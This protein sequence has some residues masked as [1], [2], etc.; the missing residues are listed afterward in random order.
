[1]K[2]IWTLVGPDRGLYAS[3]RLGTL[4]GYRRSRIYGHLD[5]PSALRAIA[6]GGYKPHRVFFL[7]EDHARGAGYS[8]C[9][10]CFLAAYARWNAQKGSVQRHRQVTRPHG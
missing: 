2:Q 4:G 9:C 7:T 1:M 6:R 8:P 10:V 5:C 3:D